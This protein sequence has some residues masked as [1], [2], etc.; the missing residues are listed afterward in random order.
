MELQLT[1][2]HVGCTSW[3]GDA[4]SW[5]VDP[6]GCLEPSAARMVPDMGKN[7]ADGQELLPDWVVWNNPGEIP[8]LGQLKLIS[9]AVRET[10]Q[11][12]AT[13]KRTERRQAWTN[14]FHED[15]QDTRKRTFEYV[16]EGE[17]SF[18]HGNAL[19][20]DGRTRRAAP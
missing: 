9:R 2:K 10:T 13:H 18:E 12:Q 1:R 3:S 16:R 20:A 19:G 8:D 11:E 4:K 6:Q 17:C 15:W 7:C 5:K 14:W